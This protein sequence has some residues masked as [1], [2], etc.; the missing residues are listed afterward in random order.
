M[1]AKHYFTLLALILVFPSFAQQNQATD[2]VYKNFQ[3]PVNEAKPR[4]WWHR[5]NG[6]ITKEGIQRDLDWMARVGIGGFRNFDANLFTPVV[7]SR[8]LVFITP[9]WKDAF[10][11]TTELAW[12]RKKDWKWLLPDLR[13]GV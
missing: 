10:R 13:V 6:N 3:T 12:L 11:F 2:R 7:V 5:K 4:V 9:E 1:K 8:K